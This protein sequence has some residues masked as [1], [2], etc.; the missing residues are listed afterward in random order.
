MCNEQISQQST[1]ED[2]TEKY[3]AQKLTTAG[4]A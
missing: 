4:Y 2:I 3:F 1:T